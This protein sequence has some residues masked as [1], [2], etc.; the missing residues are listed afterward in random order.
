MLFL[1]IHVDG[2][3]QVLAGLEEV[4]LFFEQESVGA[5][6]NVLPAG[7]QTTDDLVDER[8]H[9]RFPAGDGD[10]GHAALFHGAEALF[11]RQLALEDMT[12]IL[13]LSAAG[14]GQ[15]AAIE[16]LQHEHQGVALAALQLL[17]EDVAGDGPHL[18]RGNWHIPYNTR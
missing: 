15:I 6:V 13:N 4:Q 3:C 18:R 10:G 9:E 11:R 5:Q 17:L 14:A 2:E 1:A 8:V 7:H 16:R 12:R